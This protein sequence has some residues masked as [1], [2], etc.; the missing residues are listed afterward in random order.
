MRT[1]VQAKTDRRGYGW[2]H[3]QLRA[4]LKR[5]VDAG[6]AVCW[7]CSRPIIPGTPWHLGHD[8]HDRRLYRGPE[9]ARCNTATRTHAAQRRAAQRPPA[10]AFF[11][12]R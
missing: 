2:Q 3:Q 1:R 5:T 8:D 7:R 11:D 6:H 4:K 10:L 9:H 12:T